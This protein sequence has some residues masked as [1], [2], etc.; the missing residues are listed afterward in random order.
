MI[1][2]ISLLVSIPLIILVAIFT[3]NN[4]QPVSVDLLLLQLKLPLALLLLASLLTGVILGF[5]F[6]IMALVNQKKKQ[7]QL[8]R[9]KEALKGFPEVLNNSNVK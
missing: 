3:F 6:N 7:S 1:K 4:A 5:L 2:F 9:K 8:K